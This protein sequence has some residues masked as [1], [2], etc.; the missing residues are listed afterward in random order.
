MADILWPSGCVL[1]SGGS[2]VVV[3][4]MTRH[5]SQVFQGQDEPWRQRLCERKEKT[6]D[7]CVAQV[8]TVHR[9]KKVAKY[10]ENPPKIASHVLVRM[11]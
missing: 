11:D 8:Q 4:I 5:V 10:D 2:V 6:L 1:Y 3:I 9:K 7:M